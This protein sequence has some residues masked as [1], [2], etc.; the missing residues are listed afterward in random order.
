MQRELKGLGL[1]HSVAVKKAFV[2]EANW[3]K[4]RLPFAR[5]MGLWSDGRGHVV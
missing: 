5:E 2:S 3:G 1:N 4:K